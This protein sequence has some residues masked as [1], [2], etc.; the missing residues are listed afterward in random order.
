MEFFNFVIFMKLVKVTN[1]KLK[2]VKMTNRMIKLV[3]KA[4]NPL[5]FFEKVHAPP[6]LFP[7]CSD[8][9]AALA[10][11]HNTHHICYCSV[12]KEQDALNK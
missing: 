8:V 2:F 7:T 11:L 3:K 10:V 1:K 4:L 12:W 9:G 6:P 5:H